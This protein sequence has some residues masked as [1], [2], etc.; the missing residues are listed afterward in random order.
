MT[1]VCGLSC[2]GCGMACA[3][4]RGDCVRS[5]GV[6]GTGHVRMKQGALVVS[7]GAC[8]RAAS[9]GYEVEPAESVSATTEAAALQHKSVGSSQQNQQV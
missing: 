8:A 1:H 3:R 9:S 4:E 6:G 2:A 7:D 5:R